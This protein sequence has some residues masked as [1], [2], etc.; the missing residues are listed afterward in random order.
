MSCVMT[1]GFLA[2]F[3]CLQTFRAIRI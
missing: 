1:A 2:E 3:R